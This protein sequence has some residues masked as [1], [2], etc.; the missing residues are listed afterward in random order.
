MARDA[1]FAV[2]RFDFLQNALV[3]GL[4]AGI[5]AGIVGTWVVVRKTSSI[6][7]AVAP[8]NAWYR[9]MLPYTPLHYLLLNHGFAALVMTSANRT[10]EPI[11]IDNDDAFERLADIADYFLIHNRDIYL[12]SD[13]SIVRHSAGHTRYIRRSRGFVPIPL[14]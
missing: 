14:F 11:A 6:A 12:R 5:A 13:D 7:G 9:V 1:G 4:F 8:R 10:D 2:L 3:A